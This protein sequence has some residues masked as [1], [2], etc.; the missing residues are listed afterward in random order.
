[1]AKVLEFKA[2]NV[3]PFTSWLKKFASIDNSLLLEIDMDTKQFIA[4]TYN[5]EHSVIKFSKISFEEAGL[6]LEAEK[7]IPAD[8]SGKRIRVGIYHLPRLI[9]SIDHF[10]SGE[11]SFGFKFEDVIGENAGLSG[12][13]IQLKNSSL[14]MNLKCASLHI[15]KNLTDTAFLTKIAKINSLVNFELPN[16]QIEKINS[17]CNLDSEYKFLDLK[18]RSKNLT[19][20]GKTFELIL[21]DSD[22]AESSI[23]I[24]KAQFDKL[25]VEN[26]NV[27]MANEK[28][29]FR[30]KDSETIT[31]ISMVERDDKYDESATD[32][33]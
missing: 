30:S 15:F 28:L 27:E 17:L 19:V 12:T 26:Y 5:A 10:L 33:S 13:D 14:K 6:E 3:R 11:F 24:Y 7:T 8:L 29:I 22:K 9:K 23:S 20:R 4:K 31:V 2:K 32:F 1:M 21:A 16:L 25:D 18:T